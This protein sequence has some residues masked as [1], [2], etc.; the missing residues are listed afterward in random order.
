MDTPVEATQETSDKKGAIA[1]LVDIWVTP[2]QGFNYLKQ[3]PSILFPFFL[4]L[5]TQIGVSVYFAYSVDAAWMVDQ[6]ANNTPNLTPEQRNAM[7]GMQG[8]MSGGIA[9]AISA[10][11][12]TI[13]FSL[14][15][16]IMAGYYT[17]VSSF[18]ADGVKF[19]RWFSL[20]C[21][22]STPMVF[23]ALASAVTIFLSSNGQIMQNEINPLSLNSL[24]FKIPF[25]QPGATFL[26][27]VDVTMVWSSILTII[28]YKIFSQK[29]TLFAS[30]VTLS[31]TVLIM[32]TFAFFSFS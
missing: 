20:I 31:P 6:M 25:G 18:T 17:I 19:S 11:S 8:F 26:S 27:S 13:M 9:A 29:S 22:C 28:G 12:I 16:A 3:H 7:Q 32:G 5:L 24:L 1:L 15:F 30:V 10:V 2:S 4:V 14:I 21:W 23:T